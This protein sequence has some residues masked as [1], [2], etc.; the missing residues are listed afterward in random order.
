MKHKLGKLFDKY[1][2]LIQSFL[3]QFLPSFYLY[4]YPHV[5]NI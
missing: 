1:V 4:C 3:N 5:L 2:L